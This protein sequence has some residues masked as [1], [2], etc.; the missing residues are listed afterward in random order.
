VTA[1]LGGQVPKFV[2]STFEQTTFKCC[3]V[4]GGV[5]EW[6]IQGWLVRSHE[7]NHTET[8]IPR[9]RVLT[10]L[11]LKAGHVRSLHVG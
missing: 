1:F 5:V 2:K 3:A 6:V 9:L 7:P 4:G 10:L 11:A 8:F